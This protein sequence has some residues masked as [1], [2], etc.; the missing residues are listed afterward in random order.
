[1]RFSE[2]VKHTDSG[3]VISARHEAWVTA[4]DHPQ[5]SGRALKFAENQLAKPDRLRKGT[6][7]ASSL[8]ECPRKQQFTYLGMSKLPPTAQNAMRRQN[9]NFVHLRWQME[10]LTE[11]WLKAAEVAIRPLNSHGLSGTMDGVLYEES[12]LEIKS[13]NL[14][15]FRRI[16]TFGPMHEHLFQMATYMLT[17]GR[18]KGVFIYECKDNQEYTEIVVGPDEVPLE[19]AERTAEEMW[20]H[21]KAETLYEPREKCLDQTGYVYNSCPFKDRCLGIYTWE[22][23]S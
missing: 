19:E 14:N 3:L 13:I 9:G 20:Q 21:I 8:G 4:H 10:G 18:E 16:N 7:S 12:I 17:S 23:A 15:G 22:E 1:M 5:Y 2:T 6:V 11:G